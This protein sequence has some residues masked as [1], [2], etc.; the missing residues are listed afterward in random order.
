MRTAHIKETLGALLFA[1]QLASSQYASGIS[2]DRPSR[3]R[4]SWFSSVFNQMMRWFSSSKFL[5]HASLDLNQQLT[6]LMSATK[7]LNF[8]NYF[9][10]H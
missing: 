6:P 3:H 7:L 1:G 2:C 9:S 10:I 4:F 8:P 5:L